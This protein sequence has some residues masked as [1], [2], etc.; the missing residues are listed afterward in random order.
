MLNPGDGLQEID[1]LRRPT[2]SSDRGKDLVWSNGGRTEL[3]DRDACCRV[4]DTSRVPCIYARRE[5]ETE[6]CQ[7]CVPSTCDVEHFVRLGWNHLNRTVWSRER[8]T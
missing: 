1:G 6:I 7:D 2:C 3:R 4:C 8:H 5:H